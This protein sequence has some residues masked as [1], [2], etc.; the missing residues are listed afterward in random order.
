VLIFQIESRES[1]ANV[2][3]IAAVPGFDALLF[4]PVISASDR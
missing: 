1:L 2:E 4:G 3:Q